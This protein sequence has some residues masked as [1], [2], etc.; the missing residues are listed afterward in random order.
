MQ[1]PTTNTEP[2]LCEVQARF[3][4]WR[5]IR[6]RGRRIPEELWSAAV[7]LTKIHSLNTVSRVLKLNYTDLEKRSGGYILQRVGHSSPSPDFI[8]IDLPCPD[9]PAECVLEMS[10]KNGNKM[11]MH[12]KGKVA[13][14]LQSLAESFW[15]GDS[16]CR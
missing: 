8:A 7:E 5:Q 14:D 10:H 4:T 3:A 1:H 13:L 16:C 15:S 6:Q 11:R 9:S 12:F 2:T